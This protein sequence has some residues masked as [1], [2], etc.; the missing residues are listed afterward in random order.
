MGAYGGSPRGF[1][2]RRNSGKI[3][4]GTMEDEPIFREQGNKN[5]QIR[6]LKHGV[7]ANLLKGDK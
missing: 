5:L 7:K 2:E 4:K 3:L 1:R 6:G